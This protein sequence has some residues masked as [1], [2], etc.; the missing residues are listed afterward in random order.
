LKRVLVANRGE[1][2]L[3]II[4][5]LKELGLESVAV[6]S[7]VDENS[8]HVA[9]ADYS[10]RIGPAHP[11]ESYL[12]IHRILSAAEVS[13]AD[14]IHPGYG[15]L[16]ENPEFA[17]LC[18]RNRIVFIGPPFHLMR[19]LGDKVEARKVMD[20]AG[21]PVLRGSDGGFSNVEEAYRFAKSIGFP[22]M[23]KSRG[24]GGGRGMRIVY[25]EEEFPR[26]FEIAKKESFLTFGSQELY[27]E[28]FVRGA[29]HIEVQIVGDKR[30][31]IIHLFERECSIQRRYQKV[32]EEAPAPSLSSQKREELLEY[33]IRGAEK[34]SYSSVGTFE[35]LMDEEGN[36]YF[37]EANTRIQVEHPVT[38]AITGVD[39]IKLQIL[40]AMGEEIP[41]PQEKIEKKGS[42]I[43]LRI[44][45]EDPENDFKPSTGKIDFVHFPGGPG[46]RIDS[47]IYTGYEIT[48]YYDSLL[49][50]LISWGRDREEAILRARR[51]IEEF[52]ISGIKTNKS[53]LMDVLKD[54]DFLEGNYDTNFLTKFLKK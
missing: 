4:Y 33:A 46:I 23:I 45:A 13:G 31:N 26:Q 54:R 19:K 16:A 28:K 21:I 11:K 6:F 10:V 52:A 36:F 20:E 48:P 12:N 32:V 40:I 37:L 43:E 14:A 7:E 39:L 30:G 50:K 44:N 24:G 17:E 42:A 1:I 3:R 34:L 15:F 8:L 51:G 53:L 49:L 47:H 5:A 41:F 2:A 29:R 18:E 27:I 35:F 22:V 9:M 38:E 25:K